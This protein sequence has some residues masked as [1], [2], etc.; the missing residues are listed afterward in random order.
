MGLSS[1]AV[2]STGEAIPNPR[3][4]RRHE[5]EL[6][7]RQRH[8]SRCRKGSNGRRKGRQAVA[9]LHMRIANSRRTYLHQVSAKLI[10]EHDVIAV[11][12]LNVK[13]LASGMLAKSVNDAGWATL[14][15]MLIYKAA[16]AGRSLIEVDPR[17]TTQACSGCGVI[18]P[19]GLGDRRHECPD[20]GLSLD[21]DE[22]A[23]RNIL[24]RSGAMGSERKAVAYA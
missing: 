16:K 17:N 11:K 5:R 6:R 8:L 20:C 1:L 22:N 9:R 3:I 15:Q 2:L 13:G 23:A 24:A 18:V 10:R 4:A 7:R 14:K 19:K 21:R 12:R